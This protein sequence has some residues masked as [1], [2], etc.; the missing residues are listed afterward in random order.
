MWISAFTTGLFCAGFAAIVDA[1]TDQ[2]SASQVIIFAAISGTFGSLFA[3]YV[4][5]GKK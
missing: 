4:L 3:Q 5:K 2:L 1:V